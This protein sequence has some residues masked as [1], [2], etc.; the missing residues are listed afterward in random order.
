MLWQLPWESV[1]AVEPAWHHKQ[2][3]LPP[4]GLL[5]HRKRKG[6]REN[7]LLHD[8]RCRPNSGQAQEVVAAIQACRHRH[9]VEPRSEAVTWRQLGGASALL[10]LQQQQGTEAAGNGGQEWPDALLSLEFRPVWFRRECRASPAGGAGGPS[11]S[12]PPSSRTVSVWRPVG[13]PGYVALGDVVVPGLEP[14][15]SPVRLYR[16]VSICSSGGAGD[17]PGEGPRL[18]QPKGFSLVFRDSLNPPVTVWRPIAPKGYVEAGCVAWPDME[19]PPL[20]LVRC[21]RRDLAQPATLVQPPEIG[22]L[23]IGASSDNQSWRCSFWPVD[24]AARTF[25]AGKSDRPPT[26]QQVWAPVY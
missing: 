1:L 24:N 4:D 8:V 6:G 26:Q 21:V 20:G 15:Q 18:L 14:P 22:P 9:Y 16:D 10:L 7:G 3:G 12:A 25:V 2:P 23:W 17:A 11:S 5:V 13:P 19:E